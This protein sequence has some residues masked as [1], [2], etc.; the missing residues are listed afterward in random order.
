MLQRLPCSETDPTTILS[1]VNFEDDGRT[2][3]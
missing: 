1:L 2:A 3:D